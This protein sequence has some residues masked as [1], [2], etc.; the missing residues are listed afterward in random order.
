M[1]KKRL[2]WWKIALIILLTIVVLII[3]VVGG[4]VIYMQASY[5]R[6]AD[7]LA[8]NINN[9]QNEKVQSEQKYSIVTY[10]WIWSVSAGLYF[11]YGY[12]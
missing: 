3:A 5:Y 9:D 7:N 4:Y 2:S 12:R 1:T 11:L 10:Y 6:I 8:L